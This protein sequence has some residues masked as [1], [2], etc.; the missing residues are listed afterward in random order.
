MKIRTGFVSNSSSSSFCIYGVCK[1]FSEIIGNTPKEKLYEVLSASFD[2]TVENEEQL[3][4]IIDEYGFYEVIEC[5]FPDNSDLEF[6][7]PEYED[8]VYI[9]A[10]WSSI[11]DDETG[12]EFKEKV[13]REIK[14]EFGIEEGFN[15]Y[16]E[17]WRD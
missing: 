12:A 17:A 2:E 4:E 16:E 10:S 8:C 15:T 9:G 14:E 7:I 1:E 3:D 13:R 11:K 5:I 6:H